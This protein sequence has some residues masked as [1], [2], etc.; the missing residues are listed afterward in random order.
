MPHHVERFGTALSVLAGHGHI[1]ERLIKAF[2]Q[3]LNDID[4]ETLP[5]PVESRFRDLHKRMTSV[6][7]LNGEGA[8]CASVRKMS[9]TEADECARILVGMYGELLQDDSESQPADIEI[10]HDTASADVPAMLLKSV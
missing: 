3:N 4:H 10:Q 2:E 8:I 7:P 5:E 9:I 1:K 6:T